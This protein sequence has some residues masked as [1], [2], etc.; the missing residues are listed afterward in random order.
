[1]LCIV[2]LQPA[3]SLLETSARF[4]CLRRN[5]P[6][7]RRCG[8]HLKA[9]VTSI[10]RQS[11]AG[12]CPD[13]SLAVVSLPASASTAIANPRHGCR[14]AASNLPVGQAFMSMRWRTVKLSTPARYVGWARCW[15]LPMK[16]IC[17]SWDGFRRFRSPLGIAS[18]RIR[19]SR[20]RWAIGSTWR[21]GSGRAL[22][23]SQST[24]LP[25]CGGTS[26]APIDGTLFFAYSRSRAVS[27]SGFRSWRAFRDGHW[28]SGASSFNKRRTGSLR[29]HGY[30]RPCAEL[31]KQ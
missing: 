20:K 10:E 26:R 1:M 13:R 29:R 24:R 28:C 8:P 14:D 18:R 25:C 9:R 11:S 23:V 15:S 4:G 16:V 3:V 27:S 7:L 22:A 30:L 17:R 12:R 19:W 6:T 5:R 31:R 21:C 2:V